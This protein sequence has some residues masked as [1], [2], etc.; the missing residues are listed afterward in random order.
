MSWT[1]IVNE[2][3]LIANW[4]RI[5]SL[6]EMG[7]LKMFFFCPPSKLQLGKDMKGAGMNGI[8]LGTFLVGD[9]Y[10]LSTLEVKK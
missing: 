3:Y 6:L 8:V 5:S 2:P 7:F 10:R 4:I 9:D 1:L